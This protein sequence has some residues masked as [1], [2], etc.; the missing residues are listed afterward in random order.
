MKGIV[1]YSRRVRTTPFTPGV[2]SAGVKN[3]LVYNHMLLPTM[4]ESVEAD[5]RHLKQHVQIW[6]VAGERQVALKGPDAR[7]QLQLVTP[8]DCARLDPTRCLYTPIC[9]QHGGMMNDPIALQ[10]DEDEY[11]L[12]IAPSPVE[13][14][15]YGI[16]AATGMDVEI[17]EPDVSPLAIQGPKAD[18]LAARIFGDAV[19]DL[20]FFRCGRFE[21][22]GI[23]WLVARSGWSGQGGFEVY[24]E[25]AENGMPLWDA[26]MAAGKDLNVRAGCPNAIERIESGLLSYGGDITRNDTP[27]QA[28]LGRYVSDNQL[29]TCWGGRRLKEE[30]EAGSTRMLRPVEIDGVLPAFS[31]SWPLFA[32]ETRVGDVRACQYSPDFATNVAIAMVDR[33]YWDAG[34]ELETQ[35][36][37]GRAAVKVRDAFW[38]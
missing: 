10:V 15:L 29:D 2:E 12:S 4:F 30:R 9:D 37:T 13:A 27:L 19:N 16:A 36:V 22:K 31:E 23:N 3:Y 7:R 34:T 28:G 38:K 6:D 20:G 33:D 8:R 25:G 26:L 11:W 14:W 24:V 35:T 32:G 18:Q 17:W 1:D 21:W 5:Y